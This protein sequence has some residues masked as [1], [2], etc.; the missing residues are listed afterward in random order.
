MLTSA[1]LFALLMV[2]ALSLL[3]VSLLVSFFEQKTA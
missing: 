3:V 1:S 2:P